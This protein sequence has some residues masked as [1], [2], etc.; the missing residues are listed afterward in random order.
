MKEKYL[1]TMLLPMFLHCKIMNEK[2]IIDLLN[3]SVPFAEHSVTRNENSYTLVSVFEK[4]ILELEYMFDLI[5]SQDGK[6]EI[7]NGINII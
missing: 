1:Q 7:C 5:P 4:G 2:T 6:S 3:K